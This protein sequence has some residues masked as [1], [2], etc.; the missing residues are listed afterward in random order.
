MYKQFSFKFQTAQ[1]LRLQFSSII[2]VEGRAYF[3][4]VFDEDDEHKRR[5]RFVCIK[6]YISSERILQS[7]KFHLKSF[8]RVIQN[9]HNVQTSRML[10]IHFARVSSSM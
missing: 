1:V 6:T 7:K 9:I 5:T 3:K 8:Q 2:P 10:R 4:A